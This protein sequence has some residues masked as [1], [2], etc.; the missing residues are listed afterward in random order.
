MHLKI[1]H[2][3]KNFSA[4]DFKRAAG[5]DGGEIR[6]LAVALALAAPSR[7]PGPGSTPAKPFLC[8]PN[9]TPAQTATCGPNAGIPQL[10]DEEG[11]S[12]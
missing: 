8:V 6:A 7:R 12:L 2:S 5:S 1:E 10:W 9:F 11:R 4:T 3:K